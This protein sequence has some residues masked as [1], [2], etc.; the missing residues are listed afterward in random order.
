MA[1]VPMLQPFNLAALGK[2]RDLSKVNTNE[3]L[4]LDQFQELLLEPETAFFY[5]RSLVFKDNRQ[6][7]SYANDPDFQV[8]ANGF[9][10]TQREV[11]TLQKLVQEQGMLFVLVASEHKRVKNTLYAPTHFQ[12]L[13]FHHG[14]AHQSVVF[15]Q[16]LKDFDIWPTQTHL[17]VTHLRKSFFDNIHIVNGDQHGESDCALRC[18]DFIRQY[19]A[20]PDRGGVKIRKI[21]E[22]GVEGWNGRDSD[23]D[24][25]D[26]RLG[27]NSKE[28]SVVDGGQCD[29]FVIL[30]SEQDVETSQ[31]KGKSLKRE[32]EYREESLEKDEEYWQERAAEQ[33]EEWRPERAKSAKHQVK[34]A[35]TSSEA[36]SPED[37]CGE[38]LSSSL[39]D[40]SD[41]SEGETD[42]I[43]SSSA[44]SSDDNGSLDSDIDSE[45]G[46]D[47]KRL[48]LL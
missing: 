3:G 23:S 25:D 45:A 27:E 30:I 20:L 17:L 39:S 44:S 5:K 11:A 22:G 24:G 37:D 16:P 19:I 29:D 40:A 2:T 18:L 14:T 34:D 10:P 46:V 4:T 36:Y 28:E 31:E 48:R 32:V 42:D 41:S 38:S 47:A 13:V 7:K 33:D 12:V 9:A 26:L 1:N 35:D 6:K 21:F 8:W 15:Y 43:D